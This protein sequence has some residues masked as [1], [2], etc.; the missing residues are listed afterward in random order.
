MED[1]ARRSARVLLWRLLGHSFLHR[2]GS[3]SHGR[4]SHSRSGSGGSG[5][6]SEGS[7]KHFTGF[8][9]H[10]LSWQNLDEGAFVAIV[11]ITTAYIIFAFCPFA[12][13]VAHVGKDMQ[14]F[15][16]ATVGIPR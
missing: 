8:G 12:T 6:G 2:G 11:R 5:G 1:V 3:V 13:T 7:A 9:V 15:P 14:R 16:S 10:I 4:G